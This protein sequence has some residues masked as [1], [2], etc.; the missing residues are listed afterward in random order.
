MAQ[1]DG[2]QPRQHLR[3]RETFCRADEKTKERRKHCP[4]ELDL[5]PA[6]RGVARRLLRH[7]RRCHQFGEESFVGAGGGQDPREQR[8][9]G[10]GAYR[11]DVGR[12]ERPEDPRTDRF[13]HPDGACRHAGGDRRAHS[14]PL[15]RARRIHHRRNLQRERRRGAGGVGS[16][17]MSFIS[18]L[19]GKGSS[20][21]YELAEAY[22]SLRQ[23]LFTT[24]PEKV[25]SE[26]VSLWGV[27]METGYDKAVVTLVAIVDGTVSLYLSNGGGFIGMGTHE[28]PKQ[29]ARRLLQ[30]AA[31]FT[32]F[33]Q[34]TSTFP[35]PCRGRTRFFMLR[36]RGVLTAES[37]TNDLGHN[38][39]SLSPLFHVAHEL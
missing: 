27:V 31:T 4:G 19:S 10:L 8:R 9:A 5:R 34:P 24:S 35:L 29:A 37:E 23:M 38:R 28:G 13:A 2:H 1:N 20:S 21:S 3:T 7:K 25:G 17:S 6:W 16:E 11:H 12:A 15:H 33:C 14:L 32:Q 36:G 30:A 26:D 39:E 18:R 22:S